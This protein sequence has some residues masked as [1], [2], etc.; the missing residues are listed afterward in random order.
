MLVTLKQTRALTSFR[1]RS[2][3]LPTSVGQRVNRHPKFNRESYHPQSNKA[4][5]SKIK[6]DNLPTVSK[7]QNISSILRNKFFGADTLVEDD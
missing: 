6:I 4:K 5:I 2:K 3:N 7:N 1:L